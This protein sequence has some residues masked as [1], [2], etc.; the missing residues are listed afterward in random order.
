MTP[1]APEPPLASPPPS[2]HP[3]W[4]LPAIA[5]AALAVAVGA[6]IALLG[7][8]S[9]GPARASRATST[10]RPPATQTS[11][12]RPPACA[13]AC[14]RAGI[15]K[16]KHVVIIMQENRSFDSYFGTFP[17]AAGIPMRHGVPAACVPD[18][19]AGSCVRPYHDRSDRDRGG[20]HG[21]V[22]AAGDIDGG[23]MDGF[24][25]Q[26]ELGG[27]CAPNAPT[28]GRR[29]RPG[30]VS[31]TDVMGYHDADEIPNYWTYARDYVLQDHMFEPVS[32]WS[33]PAHLYEVS[34]WS[35]YCL[36]PRDAMACVNDP[37]SSGLPKDFGTP[38]ARRARARRPGPF[39]NWT[40]LTYLLHRH[41]VSW[42][43]YV[44]EG[45][46]PDCANPSAVTC[47]Y[48]S[49]AARTPGIW[50]PL[51]HFATVQEDDQLG[52][53][54]PLRS[55]YEAVR[56]GSLPAVSWIVPNDRVSEHPPALITAGQTYVTRLINAIM[57]SPDWDGTA[58]FLSWDDWGGF[59]DHVT[60]PRVDPDGYG[61]RVPG[62]VIS[63][64]ARKG[65]IDHQVLSSDAYLRFIEDDF[66]G[67]QRLDPRTDGRPDR[68]PDVREDAPIL[69]NL[70][71]DFDFGQRP[72]PPLIL[73]L[74]PPF[75]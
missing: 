10:P 12:Q 9:H 67:G 65:Y 24:I 28:C 35:A 14:A 61:L 6:A 45:G 16:I 64:Y 15:H 18:P 5:V 57:R 54:R 31:C 55:F 71:N 49:Q 39:Y 72:R 11:A 50:N 73:P 8:G 38:S 56:H 69:G 26:A 30:Q 2:G 1:H 74:H 47:P 3:R 36:V 63:P 68:R 44:F 62:L 23:R 13:S 7:G 34:A 41:H 20:P 42:R 22:N 40:D 58:I 70:Q 29:C 48:V 60:P 25:A 33:L 17:G 4:R 37:V 52:D 46:E 75:S 19:A 66:L 59:Y 43:Y 53:I 21:F 27:V 51:P 32:S